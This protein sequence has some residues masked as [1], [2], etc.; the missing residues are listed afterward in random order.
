MGVRE[1]H[2]VQGYLLVVTRQTRRW[3]T[4]RNPRSL[5][6]KP[7]S[8]PTLNRYRFR[9]EALQGTRLEF[10]ID[11]GSS[12]IDSLC[13]LDSPGRPSISSKQMSSSVDQ[14]TYWFE[15]ELS[16]FNML[17]MRVLTDETYTRIPFSYPLIK[18]DV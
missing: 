5:V 12:R 6:G 7:V 1:L 15:Q 4:I 2:D 17:K 10:K 11:G 16:R 13:F 9:I 3:V 18:L 8:E 14:I